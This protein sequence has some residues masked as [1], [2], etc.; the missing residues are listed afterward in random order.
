MLIDLDLTT[1][2]KSFIK[3]GS[4]RKCQAIFHCELLS[5]GTGISKLSTV[6][7]LSTRNPR[8]YDLYLLKRKWV[9]YSHP[10]YSHQDTLYRTLHCNII[11]SKW[12]EVLELQ[13]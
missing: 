8:K 13:L 6:G 4:S 10:F 11:T 7:Y 1:F 5:K 3:C 12:K 2:Y 9:Q